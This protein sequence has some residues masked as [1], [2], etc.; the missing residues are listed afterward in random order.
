[1][2]TYENSMEL[3]KCLRAIDRDETAKKMH[4]KD[5]GKLV[6]FTRGQ[7]QGGK[8]GKGIGAANGS[9]MGRVPEKEGGGGGGSSSSTGAGASS[10][11][12]SRSGGSKRIG[13][14]S[15]GN[16]SGKKMRNGSDGGTEMEYASRVEAAVRG[17][18][19]AGGTR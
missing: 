15:S 10:S 3:Q 14:N 8:A 9:T 5:W 2:D 12:T 16:R 4:A 18:R 17:K 1:M 6:E 11:G 7:Q 13:S 19:G